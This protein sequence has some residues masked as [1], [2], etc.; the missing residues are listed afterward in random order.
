MIEQMNR[1]YGTDGYWQQQWHA[2]VDLVLKYV[3]VDYYKDTG[4]YPPIIFFERFSF[5]RKS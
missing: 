3:F 2:G 1:I 4:A 5:T